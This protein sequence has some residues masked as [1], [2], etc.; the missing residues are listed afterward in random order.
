M[1][2][3]VLIFYNRLTVHAIRVLLRFLRLPAQLWFYCD[4]HLR[5]Q[6]FNSGALR[7][8]LKWISFNRNHRSANG[9]PVIY[10]LIIKELLLAA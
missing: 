4:L 6:I 1:I 2:S 9:A 10:L 8:L 3:I 5:Q 7:K